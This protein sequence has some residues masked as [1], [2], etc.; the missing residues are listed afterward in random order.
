MTDIHMANQESPFSKSALPTNQSGRLTD[1]QSRRWTQ[2]AK[3]RRQ[4]VRGAALPFAAI[5]AFLLLVSGPA[6][7]AA[8]RT[9]GGIAFLGIA[10]ILVVA[11]SLEPVNADVREGRVESVD[12][13]IAKRSG[14]LSRAAQRSYYFYVGGRR[15]QA[16]SR[17]S[18]DAAP[19]AG[20][21]R[22]YFLPR[23]RRVV[24]LEP[25]ADPP[26]PTGSGAAQEIV[27]DYARA[28]GSLDRTKMAEASARVT[29]L[30]H[31]VEGPLPHATASGSRGYPRLNADD[32]YGTWTNPMMTVAFSKDGIVTL[33]T[34]IGGIR[35]EGRWSVDENGR[36][37]TDATGALEPM[38]ASL[39]GRQLTVTVE[40]QRV[41]FTRSS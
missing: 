6:A 15:L 32:L 38:E 25:L 29:A 33:T 2:I 17:L 12:G 5:G 11:A 35:R 7:K 31:A 41:T 9:N 13:A 24:N 40:G 16:L 10:A 28:I 36:L 23:S 26:I 37:L 19:D 34:A 27:L 22:V 3:G 14:Y 8:A 1:E 20:Y 39:N 30:K 18:Y 4:S 21:V